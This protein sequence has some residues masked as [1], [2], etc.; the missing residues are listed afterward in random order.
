MRFPDWVKERIVYPLLLILFGLVVLSWAVEGIRHPS[1]VGKL[2]DEK[3]GHKYRW[4]ESQSNMAE[5]EFS[6]ER[7]D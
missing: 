3:D 7:V 5:T 4:V 1:L 2:C 6:C